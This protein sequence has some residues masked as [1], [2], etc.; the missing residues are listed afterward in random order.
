VGRICSGK[1]HRDAKRSKT[2]GDTSTES[3]SE[4]ATKEELSNND[5]SLSKKRKK[6]HSHISL[7]EEFNKANPPTI[8]GEIKKVEEAEDWLLGLRK[9]FQVHNYL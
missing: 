9:Y 8:D 1:R 5:T 3:S 2:S 4:K 6:R 7:T